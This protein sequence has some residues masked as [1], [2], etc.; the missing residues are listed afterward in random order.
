[1][2]IDRIRR[3]SQEMGVPV[4]IMGDLRGPRIRVGE[5]TGGAIP[6]ATGMPI[7]LTPRPCVGT[8]ECIGVSFARLAAGEPAVHHGQR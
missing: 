8:T 2:S 6:L 5:M 4:G 3:V 1:M 7:R